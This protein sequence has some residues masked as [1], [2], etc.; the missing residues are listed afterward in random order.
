MKLVIKNKILNLIKFLAVNITFPHKC[1]NFLPSKKL[2]NFD[3]RPTNYLNKIY[4]KFSL[5]FLL[6]ARFNK[7]E[8]IILKQVFFKSNFFDFSLN[9]DINEYT[10]CGYYFNDPSSD[11]IELI[12][13]GG[14]VFIDIGANVGFYTVSAAQTFN[15]VFS[16]EPTPKTLTSL[17][18]NIKRNEILNIDIFDCALSE[19][20]GVFKL[21]VN[22][23]NSGGN[24]LNN[25]RSSMIKNSGR[26]D[27]TTINVDVETLDTILLDKENNI[28]S[29]DLLKIDIE[30]HEAPALKGAINTISKYKPIIY[31]EVGRS[32][33]QMDKILEALPKCYS[34]FYINKRRI[35]DF[36]QEIVPM[37]LLFVHS[38]K[39]EK[40]RRKLKS[41]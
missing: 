11:L 15:R 23:L 21:H 32:K 26:N 20:P 6:L 8:D 37:D 36:D 19:K 35:I 18:D 29:V 13:L 2:I 25:H 4:S 17:R 34:P 31:A 22:P 24:S 33:E 27:W 9:L 3:E 5:V 7:S 10:Q 40:I 28:H 1:L 12:K 38:E 41:F 30:G 14:D 39:L 16:F